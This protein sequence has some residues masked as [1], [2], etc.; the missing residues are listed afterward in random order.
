VSANSI[1]SS[2][3]FLTLAAARPS[4]Y[5]E[6]QPVLELNC[7]LLGDDPNR[8]F[9][10]EIADIKTVIA[11]RKAIKDEKKHAFQH[12]DA[13]TLVL[14]KVSFPVN[15]SLK[16]N[17]GKLV[18]EESLSPVDGL[19][20][21][22]PES[23]VRKHLHIVVRAPPTGECEWLAVTTILMSHRYISPRPFPPGRSYILQ[24]NPNLLISLRC[25]C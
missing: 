9:T 4:L 18:D 5:P 19:S 20:D 7:L 13:D 22:F 15:E 25:S 24:S 16:E 11:L 1:P 23:L 12:I 17:L 8:I 3:H 21:V 14:W 10:I 2:W 6:P